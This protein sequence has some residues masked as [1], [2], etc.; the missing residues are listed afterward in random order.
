MSEQKGL[1]G[2]IGS[3]MPDFLKKVGK[4]IPFAGDAIGFVM[5]L[6]GGVDWRRALIRAVIGAGIDAGFTATLSA[7]GLAAPFT[8]GASGI[9]AT[10]LLAAY[11]TA[12]IASGGFG[13]IVGDKVSD[14]LGIPEK[15]GESGDAPIPST[16][17]SD[18]KVEEIIASV[19][20]D[21]RYSKILKKE[22]TQTK[23]T[24]P[25]SKV[26][27]SALKLTVSGRSDFKTGKVYINDKEVSMDEYMVFQDYEQG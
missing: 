23:P 4:Y 26:T 3:A 7:L 21:E 8:G 25:E 15:F 9:A 20:N 5:D 6:M 19:E 18:S 1:L 24:S 16:V 14:A 17:P 27:P 13:R 10:A 12:D 2:R 11:M 22:S